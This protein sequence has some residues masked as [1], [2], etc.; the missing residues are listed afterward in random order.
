MLKYSRRY[1]E[2]FQNGQNRYLMNLVREL[3]LLDLPQ[4]QTIKKQIGISQKNLNL[5]IQQYLLRRI[6]FQALNENILC[7]TCQSLPQPIAM[8]LPPHWVEHL[9]TKNVPVRRRVSSIMWCLKNL[10]F[11]A[12]GTSYVFTSQIINQHKPK[13]SKFLSGKNTPFDLF[14]GLKDTNLP[15]KRDTKSRTILD[16]HIKHGKSEKVIIAQA[17]KPYE[18]NKKGVSIFSSSS[19][20]PPIKRKRSRVQFIL[21][22][23]GGSISAVSH[24]FMGRWSRALMYH[25]LLQLCHFDHLDPTSRARR[26]F[27]NNSG[28]FH[29][30]LWTYR[31][32][33]TGSKIVCYFYS[34]N[35][36]QFIDKNRSRPTSMGWELMNWPNYVV[37]NEQQKTFIESFTRSECEIDVVGEVWFEDASVAP[38]T[39]QSISILVFDVTPIKTTLYR[40]LGA[41][42]E[43]YTAEKMIRFVQE[44]C[45]VCTEISIQ[46]V[47]KSKRDVLP[48]HNKRY[49]A[50]LQ[51][52]EHQGRLSLVDPNIS[53]SRLIDN[54]LVVIATPFSSPAHIAYR[55][56]KPSVYFDPTKTIM[57][58]D[59][60][61]SGVPILYTKKELKS[62]ILE[63]LT[64]GER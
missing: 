28:W 37:W 22:A 53:A 55:L 4:R 33:Q 16:W 62:F 26:I 52:L 20:L 40:R 2:L 10:L 17:P 35:N 49:H 58:F 31:A 23:L 5:C 43:F 60:A 1:D 45:D 6:D 15:I 50:T 59:D 27:F 51:R 47:I 24:L 12:H 44:I 46:P 9:S 41:P 57:P 48:V 30:P 61:R 25:E 13:F 21:K 64:N 29:R 19:I 32:E 7:A 36:F 34:T 39:N 38:K 42:V 56:S 3:S 63:S 54:A 8:A 11:I 18:F 14:V